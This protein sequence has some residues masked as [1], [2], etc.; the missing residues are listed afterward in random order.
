MG[1]RRS[2]RLRSTV[3]GRF[4]LEVRTQG[5]GRR[6]GLCSALYND[7]GLGGCPDGQAQARERGRPSTPTVPE[8]PPK[9]RPLAPAEP[10]SARRPGASRTA[11]SLRGRLQVLAAGGGAS[12]EVRIVDPPPHETSLAV[13]KVSRPSEEALEAGEKTGVYQRVER[14]SENTPF[15]EAPGIPRGLEVGFYGTQSGLA[16][17][18]R[19]LPFLRVGL[20]LR[21]PEGFARA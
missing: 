16:A 1:P 6:R 10:S 8:G 2:S 20:P 4:G 12:P 3:L 11:E 15:G 18:L 5:V 17:V 13:S 19:A 21:P 14:P 9:K 7:A